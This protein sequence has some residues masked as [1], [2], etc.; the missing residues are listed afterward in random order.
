MNDSERPTLA[1]LSAN[2]TDWRKYVLPL[3]HLMR[4]AEWLACGRDSLSLSFPSFFNLSP[5]K[6]ESTV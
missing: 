4:A 2:G 6:S 5:D 1:K 3:S